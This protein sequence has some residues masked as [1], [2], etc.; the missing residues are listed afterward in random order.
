[1]RRRRDNSLAIEWSKREK[2]LMFFHDKHKPDG[3]LL[4]NFFCHTKTSTG[5]TFVEELKERGFDI[6]TLR[7]SVL[8]KSEPTE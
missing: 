7:F 8:R 1:M 4:Y 6:T 2:D 5:K 3:H